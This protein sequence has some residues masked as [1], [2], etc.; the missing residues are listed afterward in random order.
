MLNASNIDTRSSS[1][2]SARPDYSLRFIRLGYHYFRRIPSQ[3]GR[4]FALG[5]L[6]CFQKAVVPCCRRL[7]VRRVMV[8]LSRGYY[9]KTPIQTRRAM[10][11]QLEI[12]R[13]IDG[14]RERESK[15]SIRWPNCRGLSFLAVPSMRDIPKSFTHFLSFH[16]PIRLCLSIYPPAA[17][18][19]CRWGGGSQI[20]SFLE[21]KIALFSLEARFGFRLAS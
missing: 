9:D 4:G 20:A 12:E 5:F 19:G 14:E 21:E 10:L 7:L 17:A 13:N 3:V 16:F 11:P 2:F 1:F 15:R 18:G 6:I 8:L